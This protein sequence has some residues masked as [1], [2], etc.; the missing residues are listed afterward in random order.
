M[1]YYNVGK[2]LSEAQGGKARAKY[3]DAIIK[4]YSEKLIIEVGRLYNERTRRR[5]KKGLQSILEYT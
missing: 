2:L 1:N 4:A 3:G 5:L